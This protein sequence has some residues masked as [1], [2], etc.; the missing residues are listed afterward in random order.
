[1]DYAK[2]ARERGL[3]IIVA[4]AGGAAHLPGMVASITTLPVIGVPI[5]SSN[6]IDGWDSILSILQ[7]PNGIPVATVALNGARNA[8]I[9]AATILGTS[10]PKIAKKLAEHKVALKQKV[11]EMNNCLG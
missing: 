7:M 3:K 8:G 4:G 6:S 5:K 9:L 10:N 1:M 11:L 2:T